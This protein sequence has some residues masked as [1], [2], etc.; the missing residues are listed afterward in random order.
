MFRVIIIT[1][2]ERIVKFGAVFLLF[3]NLIFPPKYKEKRADNY[4]K[5]LLKLHKNQKKDG[6]KKDLA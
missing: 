4:A 1:D 2:K 6:A 5:T 3:I